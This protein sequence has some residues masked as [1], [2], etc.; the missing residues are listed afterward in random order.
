MGVGISCV[1]TDSEGTVVTTDTVKV[2]GPFSMIVEESLNDSGNYI[3]TGRIADGIIR[4]GDKVSVE[5]NGKIIAIGVAVDLQMFGK[6]L[7][8]G[9]KGD[10]IGIVFDLD[11]GVRPTSGDVVI[12]HKDTH[13]IDTSD[14]VN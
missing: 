5:R 6:S 2:Y 3:L 13:V 4:K 8:E 14:V 11:K 12:K 9:I 10:N 7:D 1:I